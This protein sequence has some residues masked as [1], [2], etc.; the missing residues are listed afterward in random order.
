VWVW[1]LV[2]MSPNAKVSDRRQ[3]P[4]TFGLSLSESAASGSLHR[5]GWAPSSFQDEIIGAENDD[6]ARAE[7]SARNPKPDFGLWKGVA[8]WYKKSDQCI[9]YVDVRFCKALVRTAQ[10]ALSRAILTPTDTRR[11]VSWQFAHPMNP[12]RRGDDL[13]LLYSLLR[14]VVDWIAAEAQ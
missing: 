7:R 2:F 9:K 1:A 5:Q 10:S 11:P 8:L 3:P 12:D 14:P 6:P 13:D 4:Q